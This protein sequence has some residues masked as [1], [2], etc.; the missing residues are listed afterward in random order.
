MKKI[1]LDFKDRLAFDVLSGGMI[2][3]EK[4]VHI[5]AT[6]G[7]IANTYTR[8]EELTGTK[9]GKDYLWHIFNPGDS[10][11]YPS[12]EKPAIAL[13]VFK[14]YDADNAVSFAC[15]LQYALHFEGRDLTDNEAYRHLL[16]QYEIPAS[17]FYEKLQHETYKE[18]AYYD[19]ALCRQ[20]KVSGFPQVFLQVTASKFFL[21]AQGYTPYEGLKNR[22]EQVL[23]EVG[24][25]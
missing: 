18:K 10:D 9:F 1:W 8:V 22:V 21:L 6:A 5:S 4:P 11:W 20:L 19:F 23:E 15:D 14:D 12:S 24:V 25:G 16:E 2:L 7:Y 3:T 13:S 17:E